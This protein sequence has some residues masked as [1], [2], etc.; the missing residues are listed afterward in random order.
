MSRILMVNIELKILTNVFKQN[1]PIKSEILCPKGGVGACGGC[2]L[3]PK[4]TQLDSP[5]ESKI[6]FEKK[7]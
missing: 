4:Y 1:F 3:D 7:F 5:L 6:S 2:R